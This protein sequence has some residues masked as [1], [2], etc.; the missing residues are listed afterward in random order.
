MKSLEETCKSPTKLEMKKRKGDNKKSVHALIW[1]SE[2]V[3][4]GS[5][6]I[7]RFGSTCVT[8]CKFLGAQLQILGAPTPNKYLRSKMS[9]SGCVS[10][11]GPILAVLNTNENKKKNQDILHKS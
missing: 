11:Y 7:F 9:N 2:Q 10:Q 8:R 4:Q 6:L 1:V 3:L 5:K